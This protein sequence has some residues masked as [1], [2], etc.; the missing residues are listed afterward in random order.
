MFGAGVDQRGS[1][2]GEFAVGDTGISSKNAAE[3]GEEK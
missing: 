1:R 3:A 2:G